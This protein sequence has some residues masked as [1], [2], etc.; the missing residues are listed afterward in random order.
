MTPKI[1]GIN[2]HDHIVAGAG[3]NVTIAV[4]TKVGLVGL[5]GLKEAHLNLAELIRVK[6]QAD[7]RRTHSSNPSAARQ[8][9]ATYA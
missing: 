6:H 5:V 3:W 7:P 4:R 8:P 9:A 2:R 1:Y